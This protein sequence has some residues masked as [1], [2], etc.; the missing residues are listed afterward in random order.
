MELQIAAALKQV[1][2][3][4]SFQLTEPLLPQQ[5]GGRT[6]VCAAPLSI[7]GQ[8]VFDGKGIS[9]EGTVKTCLRSVCAR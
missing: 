4:F 6:V 2:E 1:G 9:V 5:F 7:T 8:Y 3:P